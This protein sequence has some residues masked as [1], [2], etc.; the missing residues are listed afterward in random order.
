VQPLYVAQS[1]IEAVFQHS[2]SDLRRS[3]GGIIAGTPCVDEAGA[4]VHLEG[5]IPARKGKG[6]ANAFTYTHET[7][8]DL[9]ASL[10][11]DWPGRA[12]VAWYYT[13]QGTGVFLGQPD[14]QLMRLFFNRPWQSALVIDSVQST[15]GF[16]RWKGDQIVPSG[17]MSIPE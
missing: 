15:M 8:F 14:V 6:A 3:V 9:S 10:D 13:H 1:C 17:F 16:F 11:K 12:I 4:W 2:T 5:C 7:W